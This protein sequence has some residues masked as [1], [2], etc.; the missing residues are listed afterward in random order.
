MHIQTDLTIRD[1]AVQDD[2][3]PEPQEEK[4]R[5]AIRAAQVVLLILTPQTRSSAAVKEHLRIAELYRRKILCVWALG[6]DLRHLLPDGAEQASIIDAR[7]P[8]YKQALD[9]IITTLDREYRGAATFEPPLP[10]LDFEP[11]NPYKG[12]HA[13]TQHDRADFFGREAVVQELLTLLKKMVRFTPAEEPGPRFLAVIG[14][15]GSGYPAA[16]MRS[17]TDEQRRSTRSYRAPRVPTRRTF[18][19]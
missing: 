1:I 10:V 15:S 3:A 16:A 2:A 14:P 9:E 19:V 7:G 8:R 12:L 11:R 18:D 6:D 17:A 13:F 5:Q 4:T